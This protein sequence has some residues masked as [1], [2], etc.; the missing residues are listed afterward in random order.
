MDEKVALVMVTLG[1]LAVERD[2]G[3]Y[4]ER[5]VEL[6]SHA[7]DAERCTVYVVDRQEGELRSTVAQ[8]LGHEIRLPIGQGLAGHVAATGE[9]INVPDA[10]ADARFDRSVDQR[11]GFHTMNILAVPVW[12]HDGRAVVG[13]IQ[14]LN[15]QGGAF[16]RHDQMLLERI[17]EAI[18]PVLEHPALRRGGVR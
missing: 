9:T 5:V 2:R 12:D 15:K 1:H 18:G 11:T 6:C 16:E 4:L 8:R 13:V 3:A 17:A 14:V 10:Y 7:T